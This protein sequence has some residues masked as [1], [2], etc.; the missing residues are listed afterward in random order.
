MYYHKKK[1]FVLLLALC[2]LFVF[3]VPYL[4][5]GQ[6]DELNKL[7]SPP[8]RG[9]ITCTD[10]IIN[11]NSSNKYSFYDDSGNLVSVKVEALGKP[12]SFPDYCL[13]KSLKFSPSIENKRGSRDDE[14]EYDVTT[15]SPKEKYAAVRKTGITIQKKGLNSVP[16]EVIMQAKSFSYANYHFYEYK[17]E[18]QKYMILSSSMEIRGHDTLQSSIFAKSYITIIDNIGRIYKQVEIENGGSRNMSSDGRYLFCATGNG[19][20]GDE[21]G[22]INGPF[23]IND[24]VSG[25]IDTIANEK[26]LSKFSCDGIINIRCDGKN[27]QVYTSSGPSIFHVVINPYSQ[28]IFSKE[29]D[30]NIFVR[31]IKKGITFDDAHLPDGTIFDLNSYKMEQFGIN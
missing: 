3:V 7:F 14:Y 29:Y 8:P 12:N 4:G 21:V 6:S 13:W 28:T 26:F 24:L 22:C 15:L 17:K 9:V 19:I 30:N 31:G 23:L 25:T 1:S 18:G 10:T 16:R 11:G 5:N 20:Y 27:F 2:L